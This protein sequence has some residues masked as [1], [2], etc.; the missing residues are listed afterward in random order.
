MEARQ[1]FSGLRLLLESC[2]LEYDDATVPPG[3]A[4]RA[5]Q[6]GVITDHAYVAAL[7]DQYFSSPGP[8]QIDNRA[9]HQFT[10]GFIEAHRLFTEGDYD[11]AIPL[12]R[13]DWKSLGGYMDEAWFTPITRMLV[14]M[15]EEKGNLDEATTLLEKTIQ[16]RHSAFLGIRDWQIAEL[17]WQL[18]QL[19]RRQGR[20]DEAEQTRQLLRDSLRYADPDHPILAQLV[21]SERDSLASLLQ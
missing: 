10:L 21:Q 17:R 16:R 20:L 5:L 6:E 8:M 12:L 19:Y 3:L 18:F 11:R 13:E 2:R 1:D 14:S 4:L 7:F 9:M 15:Y